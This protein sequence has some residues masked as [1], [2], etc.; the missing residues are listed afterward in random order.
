MHLIPVSSLPNETHLVL[1]AQLKNFWGSN[2]AHWP[3][4]LLCRPKVILRRR[5]S[6]PVLGFSSSSFFSPFFPFSF[7]LFSFSSFFCFSFSAFLSFS[8][9]EIWPNYFSL[10]EIG[11]YQ[12]GENDN[13]AWFRWDRTLTFGSAHSQVD[14][15]WEKEGTVSVEW[16]TPEQRCCATRRV[17]LLLPRERAR[18]RGRFC[19]GEEEQKRQP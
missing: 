19:T 7:F 9:A 15:S 16:E 2:L 11:S 12:A 18:Q 10:G 4:L 3:F 17:F 1:F 8:A 6:V 13:C 5:L 14:P